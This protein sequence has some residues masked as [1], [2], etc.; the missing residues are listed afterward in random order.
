MVMTDDDRDFAALLEGERLRVA[1]FVLALVGDRHAADDLAQST[2][3]E[4][5]RIRKTFRLGSDFGAWSRTV[6]R[7]Q[8]MRHF[9]K[10]RREKVWFSSEAMDRIADAYAEDAEA[11]AEDLRDAP[12]GRELLRGRYNHGISVRA[13]AQRAGRTEAGLKM[14]LMRLRRRL[15]DCIA[16]RRWGRERPDASGTP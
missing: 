3:L 15:A 14:A 16:S 11:G 4:L 13:L 9:R 5:W 10:K 12:E 8:I 1:S 6:A 2:F 7:Y